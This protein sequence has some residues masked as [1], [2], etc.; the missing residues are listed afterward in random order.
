MDNEELPVMRVKAKSQEEIIEDL[1]VIESSEL[2]KQEQATEP[3]QEDLTQSPFIKPIKPSGRPK[4]QISEKQKEHF[5]KSERKSK[6]NE[7]GQCPKIK[8]N[9]IKD[10]RKNHRR[11]N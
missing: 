1:K 2:R 7:T 6:P 9:T 8:Q 11:K 10:S 4:K 3:V 5:I